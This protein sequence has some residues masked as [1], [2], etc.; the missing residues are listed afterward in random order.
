MVVSVK[1]NFSQSTA[2]KAAR[3]EMAAKMAKNVSSPLN[4]AAATGIGRGAG[5]GWGAPLWAAAGAEAREAAAPDEGGG[6]G[7]GG[8][9]AEGAA[10]A[11]VA[12]V[13][14]A[15]PG[16]SVGNLIVGAEVGFGGKLIRTVSFLG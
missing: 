13:G 11:A 1:P 2:A 12:M 8:R 16:A 5:A 15:E 9:T 6:S 14:G 4:P 7:A 10:A 3:F